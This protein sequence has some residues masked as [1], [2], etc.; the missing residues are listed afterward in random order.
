MLQAS[1]STRS[2]NIFDSIF[3]T[4]PTSPNTLDKLQHYL[5]VDVKDMKDA[6]MW[7]HKRHGLF[8]GLSRMACDY[9]LIPGE[10]FKILHLSKVLN[11]PIATSI[12]VECIFSCG[13]LV[14][15]YVCGWLAIQSTGTS[16]CVGLW[17]SQGLVRNEDIGAALGLEETKEEGKLP[18]DWDIIQSGPNVVV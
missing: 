3:N 7:W 14:L 16:L 17:S 13:H 12:D 8:P 15:P 11:A 9:L 4:T 6:L 1:A 5:V 10:Q 2:Q 18:M